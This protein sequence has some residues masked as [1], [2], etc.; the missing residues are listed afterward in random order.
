MK[1]ITVV[2]TFEA[3]PGKEVELRNALV[4]LVAPTR[5]EVG[6][7]NY[8]LHVVPE[9]PAKFLFHEN[10]TTK[11]ALDAHLQTPHIQ[12]LLPRVGELCTEPPAIVI[13][14]RIA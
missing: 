5:Q 13:W 1:T 8:D 9:N 10:W 4:G 14:D 6:C 2:A 7:L 12:A 3:R 11:T